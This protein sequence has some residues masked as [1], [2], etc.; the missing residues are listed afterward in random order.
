MTTAPIHVGTSG[1]H[2]AH[3]RGRFYPDDLASA[4]WFAYYVERFRT[5]EINNSFY[6]LLS[7]AAVAAWY[8]ASPAD[9]TFAVKASRYITH[10]RRLRHAKD[11]YQRFF[12]SVAGFREK[13]GPIL[14]Q[15]PPHW[16]CNAE[17]LADFLTILPAGHAYTFE[18]RDP[19]WHN[20][21]I[22]GLLRAHNA[23]FCIYELA[24]FTA[25]LIATADFVYVRLHGPGGKY[26]GDYPA[27]TRARWAERARAW[28]A[29]GKRVYIYF[30]NDQAGYAAKNAL[31][32]KR[33]LE[34][35]W[36]KTGSAARPASRNGHRSRHR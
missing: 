8:D 29:Q 7:P 31:S 14:F 21:E 23:A 6:K 9:F 20:E 28:S 32:L 35:P 17:R 34:A 5:V 25:P 26:Q 15:L 27:R 24:G 11:S 19:T 18:L 12:D 13:I 10:T 3:W 16:H 2:Y 36:T 33:R 1:W 22:Y 4:H 30:D